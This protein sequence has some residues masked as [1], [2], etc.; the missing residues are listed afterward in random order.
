VPY[1][2]SCEDVQNICYEFARTHM[3]YNERIP[4]FE[5]RYPGRLE[6]A[7]AAP[8][9]SFGGREMY[10]TLAVQAAV[11]F[12]EMNKLHPFLNGNKRIACVTLMTFLTLN[13][14][15]MAT[16]W[17]E[18]YRIAIETAASNAKE[19]EAQVRLLE[20]TIEEQM[21]DQPKVPLSHVRRFFQRFLRLQKKSST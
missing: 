19:R 17:Q 20:K 2:L 14:K 18:L 3:T 7:L 11:L 1:F 13:K 6:S 10:P 12:Y 8:Q 4:S 16:T 5:S 21:E 9:R 15:W